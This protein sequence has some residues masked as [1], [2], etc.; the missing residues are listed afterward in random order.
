MRLVFVLS[1]LALASNVNAYDVPALNTNNY[2]IKT[3]GKTVFIKQVSSIALF[4]RRILLYL[5]VGII[6]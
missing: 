6:I 5:F 4:G 3:E 2:G 1:L